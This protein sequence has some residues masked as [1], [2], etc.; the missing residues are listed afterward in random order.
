[1]G[2]TNVKPRKF[3]WGGS[4]AKDVKEERKTESKWL[5]WLVPLAWP[6]QCGYIRWKSFMSISFHFKIQVHQSMPVSRVLK[7]VIK[8]SQLFLQSF[9]CW[10]DSFWTMTYIY[11]WKVNILWWYVCNACHDIILEIYHSAFCTEYSTYIKWGNTCIVVWYDL[12]PGKK[13]WPRGG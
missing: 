8:T 13:R 10:G 12:E 1:M 7:S 11:V 5:Q 4:K 9:L 3:P 6:G 2:E